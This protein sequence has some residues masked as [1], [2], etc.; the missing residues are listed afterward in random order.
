MKII[1]QV[2]SLIVEN[3]DGHLS[4]QT[5]TCIH[6]DIRRQIDMPSDDMSKLVDKYALYVPRY[7]T[8]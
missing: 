2:I 4:G 6:I 8:M 7:K 5:Q 3:S 1:I